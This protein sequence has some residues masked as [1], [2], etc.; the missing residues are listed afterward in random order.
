[1]TA[2][3][4]QSH[5]A[6]VEVHDLGKCHRPGVRPFRRMA[7]LLW[8][9][10]VATVS[11]RHH[12]AVRGVSFR[13]R[14]GESVGIVGRNGSGKSTLLRMIC[15]T[16]TPTEGS[17]TCRGRIGA[18][19]ELGA[20]F[21]PEFTG[22]ENVYLNGAILGLDR[23]TID[24]RFADIASF[25]DIGAALDRPVRTYSSGMFLRLA[26]AVQACV[27]PEILVIDE[28]IAVGD[29]RFQRK[30]FARLEELR[31]RGVSILLVSHAET[32][33]RSICDR[34]LLLE[35]GRPV[36]LGDPSLVLRGYQRLLYADG[37]QRAKVVREL[38]E[39]DP[40]LE[41]AAVPG[42]PAPPE[43]TFDPSLV[44]ASTLRYPE[45]GARI[46]ELSVLD[47]GGRR[48][49]VLRPGGSYRIVL[50]GRFD[51]D[52]TRVH[53]GVH[54]RSV[55][56]LVVTGQRHP[57]T[58]VSLPHV[59]AGRRFRVE[60]HFRL[61]LLPGSYFL[62]GGV[63]SAEEP[64]CRHRILDLTMIRIPESG[65]SRSFGTFDARSGEARVDFTD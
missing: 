55:E 10:R 30:C 1:M 58:G 33:V 34:A 62:G 4:N 14:P 11:D 3:A 47:A 46:E 29:A 60:F 35:A 43:A 16:M 49:N 18:L 6:A 7:E 54:V 48:I 25:A 26:F 45:L 22:R 8:P 5:P 28:A 12:W 44:S 41:P 15:G 21:N 63:W 56:G 31:A 19:L 37:E 50:S 59:A 20:G 38:G 65:P 27:D 52:A 61:D 64:H 9:R 36:C 53:F 42:G 24:A 40:A 39:G 23:R 32:A 2:D 51:A 13:V 17:V 57:A